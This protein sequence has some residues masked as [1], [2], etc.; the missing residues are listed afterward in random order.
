MA[1]ETTESHFDQLIHALRDARPPRAWSSSTATRILRSIAAQGWA[2]KHE[3]EDLLMAMDRRL[4][5]YGAGDPDCLLAMF[6]LRWDDVAFRPRRL[7]R[8][9]MLHEAL[10]AANVAFLLIHLEELGFQVDPAPLISELRPSL[11]KRPLLS[12]AEL[13]VFWYSQTRGRNPPCRVKP[14]GTQY[15]MRPLQSWKTPEGYRVELHGD[16]SGHV[17]LLEVHSPRFQRRPEPVETVCP[18]CGHTYRRGDPESSEFHR[19]EHRKRMRYLNPQPH[20]RML[21]ARQSEPDPE[22]VT[23]FSPAWKHREMYDRAYAFKREFRYD[24]IQWQSPK[25]EDDRQAH[26]YLIADEAGAIVGA[27]AFR[28]RESQ[29]GL[30]WVWIS[31]LHRRQGHLGQRWQAFRKRFG[32]FQVET[33]VS[34]AMRAFLAR[35]GD[36][37]LI[38]GEAAHPNERP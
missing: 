16:E 6:G 13:S 24:F 15:G 20:A 10:P 36:S 26:G 34:D 27:C 19:R 1:F 28:W 29:W 11:E 3:I 4:D 35:R 9:A 5:C 31:P 23:S 14:H 17:A 33:P 30:Q 22:L 25:G 12:S 7:A 18:D 2:M 37:A 21:A 32:D 8:D 38:E